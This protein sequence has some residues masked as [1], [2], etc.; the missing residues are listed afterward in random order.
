MTQDQFFD[1]EGEGAIRT[2]AGG[3]RVFFVAAQGWSVTEKQPR[4]G[5]AGCVLAVARRGA[6]AA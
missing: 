5:D 4:K 1:F 6:G 2:R 3:A